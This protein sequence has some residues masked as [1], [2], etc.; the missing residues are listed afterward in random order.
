MEKHFAILVGGI[1]VIIVRSLLGEGKMNTVLSIIVG[2]I[3]AF[4]LFFIL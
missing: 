2:V 1:A 4:I 3:V